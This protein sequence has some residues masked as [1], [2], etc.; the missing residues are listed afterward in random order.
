MKWRQ[1][2]NCKNQDRKL[3]MRS[4][5][6]V[7]GGHWGRQVSSLCCGQ[8]LWLLAPDKNVLW[9]SSS[10]NCSRVLKSWISPVACLPFSSQQNGTWG[11]R[12]STWEPTKAFFKTF[13]EE[14]TWGKLHW[15]PLLWNWVFKVEVLP[16]EAHTPSRSMFHLFLSLESHRHQGGQ[17]FSS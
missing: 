2:C 13:C 1:M 9:K 3:L 11:G 14:D 17:A 15:G 4:E 6:V 12:H 8:N 10:E 7:W 16:V 5:A